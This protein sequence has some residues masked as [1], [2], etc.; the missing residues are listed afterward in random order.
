MW[1]QVN[2]GADFQQIKLLDVADD[3]LTFV[4]SYGYDLAPLRTSMAALGL[5]QPLLM[6]RRRD[7]RWHIIAGWQRF[8]VARQLGWTTV[9]A[10]VVPPETPD[11]WCLL[12]S[13]HANARGRGFNPW[14]AAQMIRRLLEHFPPEVIIREHL[15]L[16]GLPPARPLLEKYQALLN[17]EEPWWPLL[18]TQRL[19]VEAGARL[20]HWPVADREAL[21]A[22]W[23]RLPLSHSKQ[24]E[25]LEYL[26]TLSRRHG[27]SPAQELA[28]PEISAIL[29][30]PALPP[31]AQDRLLFAALRRRCFPRLSSARQAAQ[32][33][34][35]ALGLS[36][37]PHIRL[38]PAPAFED[39]TWRLEVR[40]QSPADLARHLQ[41]LQTLLNRPELA[42]LC[43]I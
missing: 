36:Q 12:A 4:V 18:A 3:D 30:N 14:E 21:L 27:T 42:N 34:L 23:T 31:A 43:Q 11:S 38:Q 2:E 5:V 8:L 40:F 7:G 32:E 1:T 20:A 33:N 25:L 15:P 22:W 10:L 6:R 26:I 39:P 41:Y 19:T 16:L 17:L 35:Q 29:H 24:L 37:Y 28:Q 13:L 9:P